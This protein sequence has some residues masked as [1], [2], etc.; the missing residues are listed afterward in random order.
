M[1]QDINQQQGQKNIKLNEWFVLY[2]RHPPPARDEIKLKFYVFITVN[3]TN[4]P[5]T[6]LSYKIIHQKR[7][8]CV[9]C[10]CSARNT[11]LM[12]LVRNYGA[13]VTTGIPLL[14]SL[15][16]SIKPLA[17]LKIQLLFHFWGTKDV[18]RVAT[19]KYF[20]GVDIFDPTR[21]KGLP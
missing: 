18:I 11:I 7:I 19:R 17:Y 16:G 12:P 9:N 8:L 5:S 4:K 20:G 13:I 14:P 2:V 6:E 1:F 15:C 3:K 21:L 10:Y